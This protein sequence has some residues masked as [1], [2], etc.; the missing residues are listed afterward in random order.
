MGS[1]PE[2]KDLNAR[3]NHSNSAVNQLKKVLQAVHMSQRV[4]SCTINIQNLPAMLAD[5]IQVQIDGVKIN[6]DTQNMI[7]SIEISRVFKY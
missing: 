3:V 6:H 1:A 4:V 7:K 2:G 5:Q